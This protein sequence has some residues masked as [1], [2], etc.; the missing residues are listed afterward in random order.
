M[1]NK[2]THTERSFFQAYA[3][4]FNFEYDSIQLIK[5][6]LDLGFITKIEKDLYLINE[7][8]QR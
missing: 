1:T 3:P 8:Y 6:G 7:N 2:N 4:S 5:K